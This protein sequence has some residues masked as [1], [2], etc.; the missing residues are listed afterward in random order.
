MTRPPCVYCG[1]PR[2]QVRHGERL[3]TL[4]TCRA[5]SDLLALDPNYGLAVT[6]SVGDPER[7]PQPSGRSRPS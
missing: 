3:V 2:Q 6:L 1:L 5:H 7:E 4:P